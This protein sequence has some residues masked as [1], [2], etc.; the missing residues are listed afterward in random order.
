MGPNLNCNTWW[1][2]QTELNRHLKYH[3]RLTLNGAA[4]YQ[5]APVICYIN[6][7]MKENVAYLTQISPSV[8]EQRNAALYSNYGHA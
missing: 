3:C 1:E 4:L 6:R 7:K 5:I 2:N 8:M